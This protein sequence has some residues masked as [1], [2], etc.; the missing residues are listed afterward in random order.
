MAGVKKVI[1][2]NDPV[3][4]CT[5]ITELTKQYNVITVY[6]PG[7]IKHSR[8]NLRDDQVLIKAYRSG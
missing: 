6:Y 8:A 1:T 5:H 2:F 3:L 7:S 4:I